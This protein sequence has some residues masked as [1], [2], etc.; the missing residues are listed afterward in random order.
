M[1]GRR[2]WNSR[3]GLA[4]QALARH[5]AK[6]LNAMLRHSAAID[7]VVKGAAPGNP[8]DELEQL[9]LRLAGQAVF[10]EPSRTAG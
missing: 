8:W 6:T 3:S 5:P 7:R 4:R 10:A 9:C 2:V 1:A